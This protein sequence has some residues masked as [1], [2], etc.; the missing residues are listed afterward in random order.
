MDFSKIKE[1]RFNGEKVAEVMLNNVTAWKN[2]SADNA[3][4]MFIQNLYKVIGRGFVFAGKV[5]RGIIKV[6]DNVEITGFGVKIITPVVDILISG[7]SVVSAQLGDLAEIL[8][9]CSDP[10][11]LSPGC[12]LCTPK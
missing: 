10:G 9:K 2:P 8:L 7:K 5:E 1:V 6:G 3:F 12:A 11:I 4:L